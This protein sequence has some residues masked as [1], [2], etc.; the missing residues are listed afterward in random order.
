MTMQWTQDKIRT[1]TIPYQYIH[2]IA[3][4]DEELKIVFHWSTGS[5]IFGKPDI[6]KI[7]IIC[8]TDIIGRAN[9]CNKVCC[10]FQDIKIFHPIF[11]TWNFPIIILNSPPKNFHFDQW[12]LS[13][14]FC[15]HFYDI[16][17][18][19]CVIWIFLIFLWKFVLFWFF[20][21]FLWN[22]VLFGFL[23]YFDEIL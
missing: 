11:S 3:K 20:M 10:F 21:I 6:A 1:K 5:G 2:D 18:Q 17:M 22:F 7:G 9:S 15:Q 14:L 4:I 13:S 23:W 19:F 12:S 8:N 16:S